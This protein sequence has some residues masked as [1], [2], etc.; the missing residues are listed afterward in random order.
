MT[1]TLMISGDSL[2]DNEKL[3]ALHDDIESDY[4][5]V[6]HIGADALD[7]LAQDRLI[8]FDVR[9]PD[10]FRVS[11]L[12]GAIRIDPDISADAFVE[13]YGDF[14]ANRTTVFYCSV[15]RRSSILAERLDHVIESQGAVASYNLVGGIFRWRNDQR[16]LVNAS[17]VTDAVHPYNRFWGRLIEDK[18]A[19]RFDTED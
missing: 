14:L 2:A 17:G 7:E 12:E 6:E 1:A 15:G 4:E 11:H 10:E 3:D 8:V 9:E 18:Q 19:I 13:Q 5:S 16:P